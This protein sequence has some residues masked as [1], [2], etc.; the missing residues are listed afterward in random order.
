[1]IGN[2]K[3]KAEGMKKGLKGLFTKRLLGKCFGLLSLPDERVKDQ[4][5]N[6]VRRWQGA[7]ALSGKCLSCN[8][9]I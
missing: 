3:G 9:F 1:M 6:P 8:Y 7:R 2:W 5:S 4:E